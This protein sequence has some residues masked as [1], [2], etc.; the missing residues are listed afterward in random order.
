MP[1]EDKGVRRNKIFVLTPFLSSK[2]KDY[3]KAV[4]VAISN[5]AEKINAPKPAPPAVAR[6][7]V[8]P[9]K[10]NPIANLASRAS[11]ISS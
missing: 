6:M 10:I 4:D 11:I 2:I 1:D 9:N 3:A 8:S 7:G 5:P